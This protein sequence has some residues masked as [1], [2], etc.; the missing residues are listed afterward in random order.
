MEGAAEYTKRL[1]RSGARAQKSLGQ[2]FLID[3]Q[4]IAGIVD[5]S[6]LNPE[7]PLIEIGPG[8]GV[9]TRVLARNVQELWAVELDR[10]KIAL[11]ERELKG[12]PVKLLHLDALKLHLQEIWGEKKGYLIGN[13]PYYI[14]SPLLNHFLEQADFLTGMTVMVQKEVAARL[15]AKPGSKAYGILS[16]AVQL[17]AEVS[18]VVEVPARSF[19]PAPKVDSA[20]V[21]F[22][23]R[24][25][26]G[27]Q[28]DKKDFFRVVKA[29]FGQRRKN[30]ANSLSGG[31]GLPKETVLE[32]LSRAGISGLRRAEELDIN[33]FQ[34]LTR[35]FAATN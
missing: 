15:V 11:L 31:L 33:D 6:D 23:L 21:K 10:D 22:R 24:P 30:L 27:F 13:L 18:S 16:L 4:V 25:Y 20:V 29:A 28:V 7:V 3:D 34:V 9:L 5:A 26:P 32:V 12:L 14:T 35:F 2:N 8:L 17:A 19:W 1:L